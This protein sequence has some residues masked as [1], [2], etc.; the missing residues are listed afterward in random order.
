[1]QWALLLGWEAEF[2][3]Q[4]FHSHSLQAK[5]EEGMVEEVRP[6]LLLVL[7]WQLAAA[8]GVDTSKQVG[9]GS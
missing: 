7:G 4:E 2:Q 8:V 1:M 5:E 9:V 6:Q 3:C